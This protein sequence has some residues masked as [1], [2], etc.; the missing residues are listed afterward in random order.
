M[1][2]GK[3]KSPLK[4]WNNLYYG[5]VIAVVVALCGLVQ[6]QGTFPV[7]SILL[8]PITEEFGW[9]RTSFALPMAI[10]TIVGGFL[11]PFVG[12]MVDRIGPRWVVV[13]GFIMLGG[14]LMAMGSMA[15]QWHFYGIQ[16]TARILTLGILGLTISVIIPKW[17]VVKR[18]RAVALTSLGGRGGQF[19]LPPLTLLLVNLRGWRTATIVQGLIVWAIAVVPAALFLRRQPEDM[20]LY[21]DGIEPNQSDGLSNA[22]GKPEKP[23][24]DISLT[25]R[26]VVR[27]PAFYLLTMANLFNLFA[28]AGLNLHLFPYLTDQ[29]ISDS[30]SLAIITSWF[31]FG[32]VGSLLAGFLAERYSSRT[33]ALINI[34]V[35]A[36]AVLSL[37][38]IH[39]APFAFGFA[40]VQGMSQGGM[41]AL[42]LLFPDY[43]GRQHLGSIRGLTQPAQ[44]IAIAAG[45]IVAGLAFDLTRSYVTAFTAFGIGIC[46]CVICIWLARPPN[47]ILSRQL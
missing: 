38:L 7:L 39:S 36:I 3:I 24:P 33:V 4:A 16:I 23:T 44:N 40:I 35:M 18:G 11:G 10:G 21:P 46:A 31:F 17:F 41:L 32:I 15:D 9:T 29:G 12:P 25:P 22:D 6:T 5:W 27:L 34:S 42:N 45:P 28:A 8:K 19:V 30:L 26:Q 20:G 2:M 47:L 13:V 37:P 1:D 43:F 14:V